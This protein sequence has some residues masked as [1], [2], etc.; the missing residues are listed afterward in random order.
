MTTWDEYHTKE[1]HLGLINGADDGVTLA[2]VLHLTTALAGP[3]LWTGRMG[4]LVVGHWAVVVVVL[5]GLATG[6]GFLHR[7]HR[8]TL[9]GFPAALA[10][11]AP[12]ALVGALMGV[13]ALAPALVAPHIVPLAVLVACVFAQI[14]CRLI[15]CHVTQSSY[16]TMQIG[17]VP[18]LGP[19]LNVVLSRL[20]GGVP[21]V[22]PALVCLLSAGVSVV[23]F[24]HYAW[25][26]ISQ[27][28]ASLGIRCFRIG[29]LPTV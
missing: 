24:V 26:C 10:R 25:A 16:T 14:T 4:G 8:A 12:L 2:Y 11:L 19:C 23:L 28:T 6:A 18:L 3:S 17:L 29:P 21:M 7:V 22:D 1:L 5:S 15:L 27:I 20:G 9:E 13:A